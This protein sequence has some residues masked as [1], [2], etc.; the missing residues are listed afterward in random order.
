MGIGRTGG[1]RSIGSPIMRVLV[2]GGTSMLGASVASMLA[3][4]GDHVT[5]LQRSSSGSG[6]REVLADITDTDA[7]SAAVANHH[8]VIHC[9]AR[10]GVVGSAADFE[11][12]NVTGTRVLTDA[13][14]RHGVERLVYV[15]SPSVA[16][17]GRALSGVD[18]APANA[19]TASGH[20]SRSKA[21]AE[22]LAL[23]CD[24]PAVIAI[25]PHL[26]WGPGDTQLI[27]RIVD[28]GKA[29]RMALIGNGTAL[30]DTTYIDNAADALVHAL[31]RAPQLHGESLVVSNGEPRTV[32][33][34]IE[35]ILR[36]AGIATRLRSVPASAARGAGV[37]AEAVWSA[38]QRE[39]DPPMTRFLA[40]QLSTAHWF[41]QRRTRELLQWQPQVT[42]AEGF[43]R[44]AQWYAQRA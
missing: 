12:T 6:M 25:R 16:H 7:V 23:N 34:L 39:D 18:A 19:A 43:E 21:A 38:T 35:R 20:Y 24:V 27:G 30:I 4:R 10:V 29:G 28:R 15:S 13:M 26:V 17:S 32:A 31:D 3:E 33:E 40:E 11:R 37:A 5:L 22:I 8:A 36:A 41:D 44:L 9:A 1:Q 14:V 2:T 42:L